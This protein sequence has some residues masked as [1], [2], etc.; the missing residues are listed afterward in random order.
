MFDASRWAAGFVKP[1]VGAA[2]LAVSLGVPAAGPAAQD[3]GVP[4]SAVILDANYPAGEVFDVQITA[5]DT[6]RTAGRVPA[7]FHA[8]KQ[9][10][11]GSLHE[12]LDGNDGK[13]RVYRRR[14]EWIVSGDTRA[15][16]ARHVDDHAEYDSLRYPRTGPSD[17]TELIPIFPGRPV[18]AGDGWVAM[19][20]VRES[21]GEG[22]AVYAY[23]VQ[24][25]EAGPAGNVLALLNF[26]VHA[27]LAP[28]SVLT[29]WT[30][31]INGSG[32]LVWNCSSHQRAS[33]KYHLVYAARA[34]KDAGH[35]VEEQ[36]VHTVVTQVVTQPHTF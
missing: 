29:G 2:L 9:Q 28:P 13:Y 11:R 15:A 14:G 20:R 17:P 12:W 33:G 3:R 16:Y 6:L 23:R 1:A 5:T 32:T 7:E 30:S 27:L 10:S 35:I 34:P 31:T 4:T 19:A 21:L 36:D 26:S 18:A 24:K 25:I 22:T 8:Q